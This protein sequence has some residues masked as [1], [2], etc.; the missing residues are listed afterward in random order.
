MYRGAEV[1]D[2]G[3]GYTGCRGEGDVCALQML[4]HQRVM[5]ASV[6]K[7]AQPCLCNALMNRRLKRAQKGQ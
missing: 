4:V 7:N 1:L 2:A 5:P 3:Y 6:R